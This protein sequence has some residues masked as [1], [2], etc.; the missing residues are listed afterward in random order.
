MEERV[1]CDLVDVRE[2]SEGG[3]EDDAKVTDVSGGFENGAIDG[4]RTILG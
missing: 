3:V 2:E 4:K 1:F